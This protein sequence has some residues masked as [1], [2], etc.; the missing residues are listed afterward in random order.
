MELISNY[1][2]DNLKHKLVL[3]VNHEILENLNL[4]L[5]L[6]YQ[7]REGSYTGFEN[8]EWVGE[9]DYSPFWLVD[10]KLAYNINNLSVFVAASNIF[11]NQYYDIGNVIQ[12]GRWIKSGILYKIDFN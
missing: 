11:N 2:L 7:D 9:F 3:G 4:N 8:G 6:V 10:G 5:K 1:V 12:P